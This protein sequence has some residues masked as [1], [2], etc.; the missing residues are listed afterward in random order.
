ML[1]SSKKSVGSKCSN[2]SI[3]P[4]FLY[5]LL[6]ILWLSWVILGAGGCLGIVF[7][8]DYL[9]LKEA[10]VRL[11]NKQKQLEALQLSLKSI[12]RDASIVYRVLGPENLRTPEGDLGQGG[13]SVTDISII[14]PAEQRSDNK[15]SSPS[16]MHTLSILDEA[17][18]LQENMQKLAEM[19]RE[20]GE[21]WESTPI[22]TPVDA[23]EYWFSSGFG[24]R[25]SPLTGVKEF[26]DG[27]DISAAEGTPI[28]AP[29]DGRV[30]KIGYDKYLGKYLQVDHGWGC[31]TKY[32][33]LSGFHVTSGQE[34]KRGE[35][36]AFMGSTGSSTGPHLHYQIEVNGKTVNPI[37]YII[38]AKANLLFP[39]KIGG[40]GQ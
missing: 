8:H 19:I 37:N 30:I 20:Q 11:E 4:L 12:K 22:I 16:Q 9:R 38:T 3:P 26:H 31:T 23:E 34:V 24:W 5:I 33:H 10:N 15:I 21:L 6:G 36:I 28:V 13:N 39:L 40:A 17:R 35:V 18:V 29:A 25:R 32:G 14:T 1:L 7:Y 2:F 27:L